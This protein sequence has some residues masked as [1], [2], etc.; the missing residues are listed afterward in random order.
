M[1]GGPV[2]VTIC[3]GTIMAEGGFE[4]PAGVLALQRFSKWLVALGSLVSC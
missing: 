1:G 3:Y 4:P 2:I